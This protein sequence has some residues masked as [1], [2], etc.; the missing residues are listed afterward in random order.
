[1]VVMVKQ[2]DFQSVSLLYVCFC[3]CFIQILGFEVMG[4]FEGFFIC[5]F[6]EMFYVF[7]VLKS[8]ERRNV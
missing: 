2:H 6:R 8:L 5:V 7:P 1:M 3:V 4:G